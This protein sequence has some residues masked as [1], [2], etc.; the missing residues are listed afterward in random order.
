MESS[1]DT[2]AKRDKRVQAAIPVMTPFDRPIPLV[3]GT[4]LAVQASMRQQSQRVTS[5][6]AN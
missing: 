5:R 1:D 2:T 3:R 4:R 6:G